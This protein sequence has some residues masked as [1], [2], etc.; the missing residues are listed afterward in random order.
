MTRTRA[1]SLS[2]APLLTYGSG[3]GGGRSLRPMTWVRVSLC[4]CA[5]SGQAKGIPIPLCH[6]SPASHCPLCPDL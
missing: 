3:L 2:P 4:P 5:P 6:V 1:L